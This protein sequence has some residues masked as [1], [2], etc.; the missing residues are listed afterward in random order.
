[1]ARATKPRSSTIVWQWSARIIGWMVAPAWMVPA[2]YY[3]IDWSDAASLEHNVFAAA[4]VVASGVAVEACRWLP[5]WPLRA[6]ALAVAVIL[7]YSNLQNAI[8]NLARVA[9]HRADH[10]RS[11]IV[12]AT[13]QSSARSEWSAK[14]DAAKSMVGTKAWS[15]YN[16][17]ADAYKLENAKRWNA[18]NG[19]DAAQVT[20]SAAF[21]AEY[22][23]LKG[24]ADTAKARDDAQAEI[25]KIDEA[26]TGKVV[27]TNA[28]PYAAYVAM[29][30]GVRSNPD[31]QLSIRAHRE[32]VRA[33]G[34][35][36]VATFMPMIWLAIID[37]LLQGGGHRPVDLKLSRVGVRPEVGIAWR[38]P[39]RLQ[40]QAGHLQ[41]VARVRPV[42]RRRA[43]G[44]R[45][46][47]HRPDAG[48][49]ALVRLV[50]AARPDARQSEEIRRH[51][52]REV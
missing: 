12:D 41:G 39:H 34:Y 36:V 25:R 30:F 4:M 5:T 46:L 24:L 38:D 10:R 45:H 43:G 8:D 47:R 19:C 48:L 37:G 40:H 28:D 9:D 49:Q 29:M 51:D 22:A 35:E 20:A 1:M 18:T 27:V 15:E 26:S 17:A 42:L 23:R 11:I 32:V 3:N 44:G 14:V 13:A 50:Q 33:L 16:S 21:C 52:G 6:L 7:A 31:A 2:L